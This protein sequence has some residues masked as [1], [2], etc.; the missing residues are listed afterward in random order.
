MIN[1]KAVLPVFGIDRHRLCSDGAG[2]TTLVGAYGCPLQC[3]Y[4]LNPHAWDPKTLEKTKYLT[5]EELYEKVRI[6]H[7]YFLATGGGIVFGGGEGLLHAD[8]FKEFRKV[9]GRDWRLTVE[10][11][12]NVRRTQVEKSIDVIDDYII[13]IKDMNPQIY[14]TYTGKSNEHVLENLKILLENKPVENLLVRVPLIPDYNTKE[15]V[16]KSVSCLKSMGVTQIEEFNYIVK[17]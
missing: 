17:K 13:D 10:T 11:S 9:C 4:C 2:V 16:E 8:F 3:K 6:D 1:N 12:L 15:D 7:L 5:P 14:E